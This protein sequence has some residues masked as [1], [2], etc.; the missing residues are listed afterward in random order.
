MVAGG[1]SAHSDYGRKVAEVFYQAAK[2]EGPYKI[3]DEERLR[4]TARLLG[5][6]PEKDLKALAVEVGEKVFEIFGQQVGEIPFVKQ[7][8]EKR[9]EIWRELEIAPRGIDREVVELI[10]RTSIGV[11]QNYKSILRAALRCALADGWGGS[12]VA[13]GLQDVLFGFPKE[14]KPL[15]ELGLL[16]VNGTS[17]V[18][19]FNE[20]LSSGEIRGI[21][22]VVVGCEGLVPSSEADI[23][24]CR[25]L[26]EKDIVVIVVGCAVKEMEEAGLFTP[27]NVSFAGERLWKVLEE[28]GLPPVFYLGPCLEVSRLLPAF[29]EMVSAG[30]VGEDISDLPLVVCAPQW[31]SERAVAIGQYFVASGALVVY[32]PNFPT[33]QSRVVTDYL[34]QEMEKLVGGMW[35]TAETTEEFVSIIME[36]LDN[37][38]KQ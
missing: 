12:L 4:A 24:L 15:A 23:A 2:G 34:F 26:L 11:D 32:G 33:A 7:P 14:A 9:Q 1:A 35:R 16:R 6:T 38:N 21:A 22:V 19:A 31:R 18:K 29:A 8:P 27:E 37:K 20:K 13:V 10:H 5:L 28:K 30:G 17:S 36:Y 25:A 3:T